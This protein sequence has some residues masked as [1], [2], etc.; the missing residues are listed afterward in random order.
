MKIVD[1]HV[2]A[3][4]TFEAEMYLNRWAHLGSDQFSKPCSCHPS[5]LTEDALQI[6]S[7]EVVYNNK[8]AHAKH[9]TRNAQKRWLGSRQIGT[10]RTLTLTTYSYHAIFF[11]NWQE[12]Y[13]TMLFF[14]I[15]AWTWHLKSITRGHGV[16]LCGTLINHWHTALLFQ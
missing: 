9:F 12:C 7:F 1:V 8:Q 5:E 6:S 13:E 4:W 14:Y 15:V 2:R 3:S 10:Q 16:Q 11:D